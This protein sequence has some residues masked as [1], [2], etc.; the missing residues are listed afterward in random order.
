M[1]T[2]DPITEQDELLLVA[3]RP[4][5]GVIT[6]EYVGEPK[7]KRQKLEIEMQFRSEGVAKTIN[8]KDGCEQMWCGNHLFM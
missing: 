3:I 4:L 6:E 5:E 1:L 8:F 2:I 7:I